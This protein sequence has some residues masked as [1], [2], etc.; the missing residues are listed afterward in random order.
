M[1]FAGRYEVWTYLYYT[2]AH[3]LATAK[4]TEEYTRIC[5]AVSSGHC[6]WLKETWECRRGGMGKKKRGGG[7]LSYYSFGW[8]TEGLENHKGISCCPLPALCSCSSLLLFRIPCC[9]SVSFYLSISFIIFQSYSQSPYLSFSFWLSSCLLMTC[10]SLA[11]FPFGSGSGRELWFLHRLSFSVLTKHWL[12]M[13][14]NSGIHSAS[15]PV[16]SVFFLFSHLLHFLSWRPPRYSSCLP[17]LTLR[18]CS[19]C[20][21]TDCFVAV[22]FWR[23]NKTLVSL[24]GERES[25][26]SICKCSVLVLSVSKG[27]SYM[28]LGKGL[29]IGFLMFGGCLM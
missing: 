6:H 20:L 12:F 28:P 21:R 8:R 10:A 29:Q 17:P 26:F 5:T 2:H 18:G 11:V 13:T 14:A 9:I 1:W 24:V 4:R 23:A 3:F 25:Q 27:W 22:G 19:S 7:V 15:I 16:L